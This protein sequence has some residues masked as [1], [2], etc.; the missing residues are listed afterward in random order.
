MVVSTIYLGQTPHMQTSTVPSL[1]RI[2]KEKGF[3]QA[4]LAE[5]LGVTSVTVS[6]WEAG[7]S[8]P[9]LKTL[10]IIAEKLN[11]TASDLLN[12]PT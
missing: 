1:A 11:V 10:T 9:P 2:R 5:A 8:S 4:S 6:N 7:R 12:Q 3:T